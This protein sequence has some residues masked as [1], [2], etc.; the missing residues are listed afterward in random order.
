[1]TSSIRPCAQQ[2]EALALASS[3][4]LVDDHA[5]VSPHLT[6]WRVIIS[7]CSHG[8]LCHFPLLNYSSSSSSSQ[9]TSQVT[10][11]QPRIE[12][13]SSTQ[14]LSRRLAVSPACFVCLLAFVR[15][16][17]LDS[18]H[19]ISLVLG[20]TRALYLGLELGFAISDSD[21]G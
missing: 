2:L 21:A 9:R 6:F 1:M 5:A 7:T 12:T 3:Q 13:L 11:R 14:P 16:F 4:S 19:A 17:G 20:N 10:L 8:R 15:P 18:A